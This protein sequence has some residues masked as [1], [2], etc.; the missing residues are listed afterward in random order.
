MT[1]LDFVNFLFSFVHKYFIILFSSCTYTHT[2]KRKEKNIYIAKFSK[3]HPIFSK[4]TFP[5]T[6]MSGKQSM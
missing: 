5:E 6:K 4:S 1:K 3:D 2:K